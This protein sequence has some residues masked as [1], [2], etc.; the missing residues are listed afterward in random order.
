MRIISH[1]LM[2]HGFPNSK[3]KMRGIVNL[4]DY[5][6]LE[7]KSITPFFYKNRLFMG[8]YYPINIESIRLVE[9]NQNFEFILES[10]RCLDALVSDWNN[11]IFWSSVTD[12]HLKTVLHFMD[13]F[14]SSKAK[15][16]VFDDYIYV[17][18]QCFIR[19]KQELY[20]NMEVIYKEEMARKLAHPFIMHNIEY[21]RS[22]RPRNQ[23]EA[24]NLW[25]RELFNIF[26]F[27]NKI[28]MDLDECQFTISLWSLLGTIDGT[29]M[30]QVIMKV[31]SNDKQYKYDQVYLISSEL[32]EKYHAANFGIEK[33]NTMDYTIIITRKHEKK[34]I[35]WYI[36]REQRIITWTMNRIKRMEAMKKEFKESNETEKNKCQQYWFI[37]VISIIV[38]IFAIFWRLST[39]PPCDTGAGEDSF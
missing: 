33:I 5:A 35:E 4:Y 10:L 7:N 2:F 23:F 17:L 27:A 12:K 25:K 26:K 11:R 16:R 34:E 20:L 1:V 36:P 28:T 32:E 8:G 13:Y 21:G 14:G 24:T 31:G 30:Q 3:K 39:M 29:E 15:T 19:N 38:P 9:S 22:D 37:I 6:L 18:F